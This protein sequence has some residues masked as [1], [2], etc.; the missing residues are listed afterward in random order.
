MSARK[1]FSLIEVMVTLTLMSVVLVSV[2]K[3]GTALAVRGRRN[4]VLAKRN[5][6]LQLEANKFGAVPFASLANW[7]TADRVLTQGN[8]SYTRKLSIRQVSP[9]RYT[10]SITV[11][12]S[13]DASRKDS[14]VF[15]RTL[16]SSGTPLCVGC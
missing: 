3:V 9:T 11:V 1:G 13:V 7:S 5:A 8:F 4:D 15:D 14:I 2:A 16:P 6:A 10:V 12:P